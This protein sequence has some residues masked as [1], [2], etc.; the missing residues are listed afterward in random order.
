MSKII[1]KNC[2]CIKEAEIEI[3]ENSLN[4]KYAPNGTGKTTIGQAIDQKINGNNFDDYMVPLDDT[5]LTPEVI[6]NYSSLKTFNEEYVRQFIFDKSAKFDNAYEIFIKNENIETLSKEIKNKNSKFQ[7]FIDN[8]KT[9]N[10]FFDMINEFTNIVKSNSGKIQKRGGISEIIKGQG[11]G[12]DKIHELDKFK[13]FYKCSHIEVANWAKWRNEYKG[14]DIYQIKLCPYCGNDLDDNQKTLDNIFKE[15][16]KKSSLE[17]ANK[18]VESLNSFAKDELVNNEAKNN[19]LSFLGNKNKSKEFETKLNILANEA[20]YLKSKLLE[21]KG[22]NIESLD[23]ESIKT[24]DNILDQLHIDESVLSEFFNTSMISNEIKNINKMLDSL[25]SN[26]LEIRNLLLSQNNKLNK[27]IEENENDIK[28]FFEIAGFPYEFNI[29]RYEDGAIDTY[30]TLKN[31]KVENPSRYLSWGERNAFAVVMFMFEAYNENPE[32]IVLDDPIS[33]VDK[34]KK[35]SIM[36]RLFKNKGDTKSFNKKT[37][38]FL[39]H[40]D[41]PLVDYVYNKQFKKYSEMDV[42]ACYLQNSNGT[43]NELRIEEDDFVNINDFYNKEENNENLVIKTVA[44]RKQ[45]EMLN[46]NYM[47]DYLYQGLSNIIHGRIKLLDSNENTFDEEDDRKIREETNTYYGKS[48]DDVLRELS[49]SNLKN[50][51]INS[52]DDYLV[53]LSARLLFERNNGL[54]KKIERLVPGIKKFMDETNHIENDYIFQLNPHKFSELP[55]CFIEKIKEFVKD[56]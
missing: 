26:L 45:I 19:L 38:L 9:I 28:E 47:N 34:Y 50:S 18:L 43:I 20:E 56:N 17:T 13:P 5:L 46:S 16:F 37:V 6:C 44:K 11:A 51:I 32:L 21:I 22:L 49:E 36:K 31:S 35:F 4:I 42:F 30:L 14:P 8:N 52:N 1:I 53:V 48:Y 40:E 27:V 54:F 39:T 7:E 24:L 3:I 33:S 23:K 55:K 15:S 2:K 29:K 12:F 25:K 41:Q 10:S